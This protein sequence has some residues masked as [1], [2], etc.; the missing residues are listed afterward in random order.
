MCFPSVK[1]PEMPPL[2]EPVAP[3]QV[4]AAK[5][6]SLGGGDPRMDLSRQTERSKAARRYGIGKTWITD[7]LV[8]VD[9]DSLVDNPYG[10]R[11]RRA[12]NESE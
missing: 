4:I 10:T 8:S 9:D 3:T 11:L 1:V 5:D 7:R 6:S 2:P 12:L